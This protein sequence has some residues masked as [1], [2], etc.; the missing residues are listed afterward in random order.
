MAKFLVQLIDGTH[1]DVEAEDW[2]V[3]ENSLTFMKERGSS[4]GGFSLHYVISWWEV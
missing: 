2:F 1:R 4:L 3:Q